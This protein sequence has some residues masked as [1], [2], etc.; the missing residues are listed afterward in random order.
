MNYKNSKLWEGLGIMLIVMALIISE[1]AIVEEVAPLLKEQPRN[2]TE[3]EPTEYPEYPPRELPKDKK[4]AVDFIIHVPSGDFIPEEG[5]SPSLRELLGKEPGATEIVAILQFSRRLLQDEEEEVKKFFEKKGIKYLLGKTGSANIIRL[6]LDTVNELSSFPFVRWLGEYKDEYKYAKESSFEK[7]G[8]YYIRHLGENG[9]REYTKDL[10]KLRINILHYDDTIN[11]YYIY[12]TPK[13]IPKVVALW[14]VE[15][16]HGAPVEIPEEET[17]K[18]EKQGLLSKIWSLVKSFFR[19]ML[20]TRTFKISSINQIKNL[21]V[22]Q[23]VKLTGIIKTGSQIG[24]E[25]CP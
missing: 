24:V 10:E 13:V 4:G 8:Y 2:I 1:V 12:L 25:Y 6:R 5:I 23:T 20:G 3:Q 14:W 9:S 22:G 19:M 17:I 7:E 11:S 21:K 15:E 18:T 16:I